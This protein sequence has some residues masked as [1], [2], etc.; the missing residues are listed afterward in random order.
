VVQDKLK[1]DIQD[2]YLIQITGD[3]QN[4]LPTSM[5]ESST[6]GG[7]MRVFYMVHPAVDTDSSQV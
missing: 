2:N 1:I 3:V 6:Q 4:S 7:D 5:D